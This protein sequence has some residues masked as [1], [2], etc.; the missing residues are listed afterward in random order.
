[1]SLQIALGEVCFL[2]LSVAA[3]A[4][5]PKPTTEVVL[6]HFASFRAYD[7]SA[8][9]STDT[10]RRCP[11]RYCSSSRNENHCDSGGEIGDS[12]VAAH[13]NR[14]WRF[15]GRVSASAVNL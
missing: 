3:A 13:S 15:C 14:D 1:M 8:S 2:L 6:A 10:R 12:I 4:L 9:M 11:M 5:T 7:P